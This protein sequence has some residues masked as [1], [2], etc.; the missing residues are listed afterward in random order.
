MQ[1]NYV[2]LNQYYRNQ[3][4]SKEGYE[5]NVGKFELSR[6]TDTPPTIRVSHVDPSLS[7]I[8]QYSNWTPFNTD[9][10]LSVENIPADAEIKS[11]DLFMRYGDNL[12]APSVQPFNNQY[13][14]YD[15]STKK[16]TIAKPNLAFTIQSKPAPFTSPTCNKTIPVCAP[17]A[18][19]Y[20][21]WG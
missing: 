12:W 4:N 16:I 6:S 14:S 2:S 10:S 9:I 15:K 21:T 11:V 18:R 3:Y 17:F 13:I 19:V 20:V 7:S 5:Y 8:T 1:S